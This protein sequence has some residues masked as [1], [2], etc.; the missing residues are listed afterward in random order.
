MS[1]PSNAQH[2]EVLEPRIPGPAHTLESWNDAKEAVALNTSIEATSDVA[3]AS[4]KPVLNVNGYNNEKNNTDSIDDAG[5]PR[6][7]VY[8]TGWRLHALTAG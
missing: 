7:K 5:A 8:H 4:H 1:L 3:N 6:K 2:D